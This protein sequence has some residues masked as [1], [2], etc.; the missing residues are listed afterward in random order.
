[1]I[2]PA[3]VS[4]RFVLLALCAGALASCANPRADEALFAHRRLVDP[5][6]RPPQAGPE[7]ESGNGR[8]DEAAL[9]PPIASASTQPPV[10]STARLCG[11]AGDAGMPGQLPALLP[12]PLDARI[13]VRVAGLGAPFEE[14]IDSLRGYG[15]RSKAGVPLRR[16]LLRR[17]DPH[18]RAG[19]IAP[20]S[21]AG[22]GRRSAPEP[23]SCAI[24]PSWG[25]SPV[26][27]R[28][29]RL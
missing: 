6:A 2:S 12:D 29:A 1:M 7:R 25:K 3:T 14:V 24:P 19:H 17:F 11:R 27:R 15:G 23:A 4:L 9:N 16:L 22:A 26:A 20:H 10:A 13:G 8:K 28:S 5:A 18:R 21:S